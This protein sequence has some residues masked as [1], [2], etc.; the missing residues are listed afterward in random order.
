M[1][2]CSLPI[3]KTTDR[4]FVILFVCVAFASNDDDDNRSSRTM[5]E[6]K[7]RMNLL[8]LVFRH[9]VNAFRFLVGSLIDDKRN[10]WYFNNRLCHYPIKPIMRITCFMACGEKLKFDIDVHESSSCSCRWRHSWSLIK[11]FVAPHLVS[12]AEIKRTSTSLPESVS[13]LVTRK[14]NVVDSFYLRR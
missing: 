6:K 9:P 8:I 13:K 5:E 7:E 3:L 12:L 4:L 11:I 10:K 1:T 2:R 14:A